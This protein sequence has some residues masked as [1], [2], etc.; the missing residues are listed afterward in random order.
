M[1]KILEIGMQVFGLIMMILSTY[2][3]LT[4]IVGAIVGA[5]ITFRVNFELLG[6][7]GD[8]AHCI[9]IVLSIVLPVLYLIKEW[10]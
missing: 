9:I 2:I 1:D 8:I 10:S 5:E 4:L 6:S 7:F 3:A